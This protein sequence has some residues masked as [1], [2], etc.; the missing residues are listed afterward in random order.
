MKFIF[1]EKMYQGTKPEIKDQ[2]IIDLRDLLGWK[3]SEIKKVLDRVPMAISIKIG[4][5]VYQ[6][7]K[8]EILKQFNKDQGNVFMVCESFCTFSVL[9]ITTSLV[10]GEGIS[11]VRRGVLKK[12]KGM[13]DE[14][15]KKVNYEI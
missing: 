9:G 12:V 13:I 3:P 6:G 4:D 7:T 1:R 10:P 15:T 11:E 14:F 2:L 8:E 5:K